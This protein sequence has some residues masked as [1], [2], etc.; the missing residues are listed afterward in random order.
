MCTVVMSVGGEGRLWVAANRDEALVRTATAPRRWPNEPFVAPRDEVGHGTWL[1]LSALGLFVG[2]TNRF[3][4]PRDDT[5]ESRGQL[6]VEA[7]RAPSIA[8]LHAR[9]AQLSPARFNA[10]HL[11]YS[12]G[13]DCFVTW[14]DGKELQQEPLGHG[15]HVV[16]ERSYGAVPMLRTAG[17]LHREPERV[18]FIRARLAELGPRPT[19]EALQKLLGTYRPEAPLDSPCVHLPD[20]GYGTRSSLV[21]FKEKRVED[22]DWRWAEGPP[23]RTPFVAQRFE[24]LLHPTDPPA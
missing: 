10:F 21:L 14:S 23:D 4:A 2:V 1:G 9:L 11:I 8:A 22:S 24:S 15:L 19:P 16:T 20:F 18:R 12:D 7:L 13:D 3:G 17:A 5:R 6:V